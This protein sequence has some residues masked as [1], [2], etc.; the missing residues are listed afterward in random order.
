LYF[1]LADEDYEDLDKYEIGAF[2]G[3][4]CRGLAEKLELTEGETCLYMR[5]RSNQSS[6]EALDFLLRNK[7]SG[8]TVVLKAKD[9]ADFLFKSGDRIGLPSDPFLMTRFYNVSVKSEGKGSVDFADGLYAVGSVLD[10]TAVPSDGYH[11]EEWSDGSKDASLSVTV[12][13]DLEIVATFAPNTYKA[14]FEI[15]GEEVAVLDVA[16]DSA[17]EAPEAPAKVGYSFDGWADIPETMPAHD[18][19]VTGSYTI[20]TYKAVFKVDDAVVAS[21]DLEYGAPVPTPETPVREGYSFNGWGELPATMPAHDIEMH[22]SYTI[23]QYLLTFRIGDEV[24]FSSEVAYGANIV[25][26]EAPAKDGYVFVGWADL[27]SVMPAGNLE[28][29]GSYDVIRYNVTFRIGD[30]VI[31]EAKLPFGAELKA[32]EAPEREGYSFAGWGEYPTTMPAHDL[33]VS[34]SYDVNSYMLT[35]VIGEETILSS[36]LPYGTSIIAPEAPAKDGYSFKGWD[37]VPETMPAKDLTVSGSYEI[38]KYKLTFRIGEEV[39]AE[40]ELE[41]GA[42]VKSPE[43][44]E[45]EGYTFAG[46]SEFPASMPAYNVDVLGSYDVNMYELSFTIG[47]EVIFS[48][49]IPYG[50]SIVAP[51]APARDGYAFTGWGEVPTVMPAQDLPFSGNYEATEFNVVYKVDGEVV[52]EA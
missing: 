42:E 34:G 25:A 15:D 46:W 24:I 44:P 9:G 4:E 10:L 32:P 38:N 50:S 3:D 33:E 11:F 45:K 12:D 13:G 17:I 51:E 7:E 2:V 22:S 49:K 6:G 30:E 26:P 27:P 31:S 36:E 52:Y 39:I 28:V 14:V 5:I 35:F 18:I 20:N 47:D 40:S 41:Y 8:D 16:C 37:E 19:T 21:Y 43:A 1:K 29:V 48:E 23:N